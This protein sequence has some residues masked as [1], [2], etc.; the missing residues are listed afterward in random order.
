LVNALH[1]LAFAA[2]VAMEG[3]TLEDLHAEY[4]KLIGDVMD[5]KEG[6]VN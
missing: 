6:T 3:L 1:K 4:T 5:D 2:L